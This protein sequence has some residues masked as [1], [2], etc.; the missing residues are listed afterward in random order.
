MDIKII[1]EFLKN[2]ELFKELDDQEIEQISQKTE[3]KTFQANK[4][5][6]KENTSR[7]CLD[8]ISLNFLLSFL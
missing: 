4:N 6:F 8:I 5:I 1:T 2:I 3:I 7:E